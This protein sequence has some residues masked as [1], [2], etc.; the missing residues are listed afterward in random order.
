MDEC[1]RTIQLDQ[2]MKWRGLVGTGGQAKVLIQ[3]GQ[4]QVNGQV[5]TRRSRKL[6]EGDVVT[7]AGQSHTVHWEGT[8]GRL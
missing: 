6:R 2:F 1:E 5:E 3:S 8:A 7:Y 4:V